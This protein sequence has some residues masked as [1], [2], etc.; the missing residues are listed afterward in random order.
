MGLFDKLAF[1]IGQA[2]EAGKATRTTSGSYPRWLQQTGEA[3]SY[4]SPNLSVAENQA[5]LYQ[6]LSWVAIAVDHVSQQVA[7]VPLE[8]MQMEGEETVSIPNHP[9]EKL[10][11]HPNPAQSRFELLADIVMFLKLTGNSYIYLNRTSESQPPSELWTIPAHRVRPLPDGNMYIRGYLYDPGNGIEV[12]LEPWEVLH[13]KRT[14][15]R[16]RYV[17]VSPIEALAVVATGDMAMQSWNTNYF[18]KENAKMPGIL[19]FK[20]MIPDTEWETIQA[21][22]RDQYGG[23]KR[24]LMM[25]RGT[26]D[27][28]ISWV[29]TAMSQKDMEF[30]NARKF[31]K[32]EI[33]D[34]MAPGLMSWLSENSTEA[35]SKSGKEAFI[36]LAVWPMCVIIQE[37]I[38]NSLL[39]AYGEN[40]VAEFDD[41]RPKDKAMRLMEQASYERTHTIEEVRREYYGDDPLGD[42]RDSLLVGEMKPAAVSE[43]DQEAEAE[44][45]GEVEAKAHERDQ[46]R[47]YARKRVEE[48]NPGKVAD[49][50]FKY[51]DL[52]E[53]TS[54]K[55]E[56]EVTDDSRLES[57]LVMA[58]K[59][60]ANVPD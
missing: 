5:E 41:I 42:E 43:P 23:T 34:L 1:R 50:R 2:Y 8:V 44:D 52:E 49:F 53:Q 45:A 22:F 58:I 28:A 36:E 26:G 33:F 35:N 12:P 46:F 15:P 10:L 13:I 40:L 54:L 9:F 4:Y 38:T 6:R 32:Q 21:D 7:T 16:N 18:S 51:L 48:G 39:P 29:P 55:A 30:L 17:G 31:N 11:M 25:L 57:E 59:A 60:L 24:N 3:L 19:T 56:F 27:G 47:R 20:D 14:N 37:K